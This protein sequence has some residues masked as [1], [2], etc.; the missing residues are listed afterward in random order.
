MRTAF[1]TGATGFIGRHLVDGLLARGCEVTCLVRSPAR[2]RHLQR[3]GVRLVPGSLVD[4]GAWRWDLA[5]HDTVFNVGGLV[6]A[7]RRSEL[8]AVNGTAVAGLADACADLETPP[9]LVQVS[10][11][12]A[13]GPPPVGREIRDESDPFTPVSA[14]GESKLTGEV[15][16]RRRAGRLA[17]TIVQPGVVFGPHDEKFLAIY[18]TVNTAR[19]HLAMGLRPVPL[20]LIHVADLVA[21]LLA[22]ADGGERIAATDGDGRPN[23]VYHAV[24][25]GEHPSYH[26]LGHRVAAALDRRALVLSV[27]VTVAA[28]ATRAIDA[29]TWLTGRPSIVSADKLREATARSW[30]ASGRKAREQIGFRPAASLDARLRE[31]A[32]WWRSQG[33]L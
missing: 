8:F 14:Y 22:A 30:A 9:T 3:D 19:V 12:A 15:E 11:L 1:V 24:D 13:A 20:S 17:I 10:S 4:I 25:D 5:G 29:V 23:G 16:L 7:C 28:P 33:R 6:A 2:A 26:E 27:P 32:D 31:T 21:L 18:Q